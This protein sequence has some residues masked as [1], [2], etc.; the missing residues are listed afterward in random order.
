LP[1]SSPAHA[2]YRQKAEEQTAYVQSH[3]YDAAA[4][5]YHDTYPI[6]PK[7]LPWTFTWG[8]GVQFRVLVQAAHYDPATYQPTLEAFSNGVMDYWDNDPIGSPPGF[9][10]YCSGPGGTDKYYDDNAW[11]V[12]GYIEAYQST[13]DPKYLQRARETQ[14]FV[15]SG[16]DDKLGG[17]IYWSLKHL[18]KNT[19][20]NAP[21]AVA[22]LRLGILGSPEQTQRGNQTVTWVDKTLKASDGLYWDAINLN[23]SIGKTEWTYNSALMIEAFVTQFETQGNHASL[24][25]A[26]RCANESI[27]KWQD[28]VT[29]RF[30]NDSNF[31]H[32]LCE[33]LLML[34]Q[35]D[36]NVRY[37]DAVRRHAA[38]GYRHVRDV[39]DGGYYDHWDAK[40]YTP[41][42]RKSLLEQASDADLF[43]LLTPYPDIDELYNQA[44]A[45]EASGDLPKAES[46][47][48]E[49]N[50][51]D[52]EAT[53][54][55]YQ[56]WKLLVKTHQSDAASAVK[57]E[58][59]KLGVDPSVGEPPSE[60]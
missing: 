17:G 8:N 45:A 25:E 35:V 26:E 28:R 51:S 40:T 52:T 58:L 4:E 22:A 48:T 46:L 13:H 41:G 12:L 32:L 56:L 38:Y 59:I 2:N 49:A 34:Y 36:H 57:Q 6:K 55:R 33:S 19:C 23:G 21:A 29:G 39:A 54:P 47:L 27:T 43:W 1:F 30:D 3:F 44:M 50:D 31:T 16:W 11:M 24:K 42:E 10:A 14:D 37:L 7:G 53:K 60:N 9:N 20:D 5:K 15:F 18:S